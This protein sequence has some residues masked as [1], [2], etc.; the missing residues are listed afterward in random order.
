M[1]ERMNEQIKKETVVEIIMW[2][3][4]QGHIKGNV[5]ILI[6]NIL[7]YKEK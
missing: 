3:K 4:E 5:D 2:A 1:D 7:E 6:T